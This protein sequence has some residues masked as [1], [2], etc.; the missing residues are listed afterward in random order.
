MDMG[1]KVKVIAQN[2]GSM[3]LAAVQRIKDLHTE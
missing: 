2:M 3:D 1:A